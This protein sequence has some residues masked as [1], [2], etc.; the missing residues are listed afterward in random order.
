M[1]SPTILKGQQ[2]PLIHEAHADDSYLL[3]IIDGEWFEILYNF[4]WADYRN[5][6]AAY[7]D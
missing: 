7:Y 3:N 5:H 1:L 6:A 2:I 4:P